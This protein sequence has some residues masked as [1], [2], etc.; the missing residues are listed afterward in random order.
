M[1]YPTLPTL[2]RERDM[3]EAF[4]GYNHNLRVGAGEFYNMENLTGDRYPILSPRGRR[5]RLAG[6]EN[7]GGMAA[8]DSLCYTDGTRIVVNGYPV[9]LGLSTR[10]TMLPKRLVT[11]GGYI[12]ILPDKKWINTLDLTD[13]GNLEAV[14]ESDTQVSVTLCT[15]SGQGY[16]EP[17]VGGSEPQ[18]PAN[19]DLWIDTSTAPHQL[20]QWSEAGG[21]WVSIP[22]TYLKIAAPGIGRAFAQYDGVT[23]SGFRQEA[24]QE[25]NGSHVIWD[26]GEDHIVV[27]GM[28]DLTLTQTPEEGR[29]RVERRMPPMD[30]VTEAGNRL[31]GCRYGMGEDGRVVN[32]IYASKLGDFKNWECYMGISTD[33]WTASVGSDGPF[34]AAITLGG[35]P[36]F[37]KENMLHRVYISSAGGHQIQDTPCR[38]VARGSENSPAIV[39][40]RLYYHARTG[41]CVYDGSLPEEVSHAF[42]SVSYHGG[43][44]GAIGN[45]Y[46]LSLLDE[47]EEP[48]LFVFDTRQGMWHREDGLRAAAFCACR[49]ELYALEAGTG[50]IHTLLGGGEPHE[51][52][53]SWWAETGELTLENPD[54]K[55]I[56]RIL[57]RLALEPGASLTVQAEYDRHPGWETLGEITAGGLGS[58]SLPV[59]PRRCDHLR[60]RLAGR[61]DCRVYSLCKYLVKGSD[62]P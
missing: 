7:P 37:F 58:V 50:V 40:E 35:S 16:E 41:V 45:K 48:H 27:I 34:T 3:V 52:A 9:E 43:V 25:L 60:L 44:G 23:I 38:G 13:F 10:E 29:I 36:L 49:G 33:S 39:N 54:Q 30:F 57:L 31:W 51:E 5:G 42:G 62:R 14:W 1:K 4:R 61:G 17:T 18:N 15:Q 11:M 28:T 6:P 59:R 19:T 24:L 20:K 12:V 55:Y 22:T 56:Q 53:V 26:R 2:D 8:C 21:M 32:E 46:Y 47:G